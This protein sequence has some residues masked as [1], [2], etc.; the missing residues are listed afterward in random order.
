MSGRIHGARNAHIVAPGGRVQ[1]DGRHPAISVERGDQHFPQPAGAPVV[2]HDGAEAGEG[3]AHGPDSPGGVGGKVRHLEEIVIRSRD[4]FHDIGGGLHQPV[5]LEAG[6]AHVARAIEAVAAARAEVLAV[7]ILAPVHFARVPGD[8]EPV[9]VIAGE[10]NI[11]VIAGRVRDLAALF[12]LAVGGQPAD[13]DIE[14]AVLVTIPADPDVAF[15]IGGCCG[16]P[17][18][19]RARA[20]ARL[21]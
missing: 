8:P 17:V 21:R 5:A 9:G 18:V 7:P 16:N 2:L 14:V 13:E 11:G 4:G 20:H 19:A 3:P 12:E 10:R 15:G 1:L 6:D